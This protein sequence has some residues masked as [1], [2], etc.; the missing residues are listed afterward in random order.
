LK[1]ALEIDEWQA[2]GGVGG[3][4]RDTR[5]GWSESEQHYPMPQCT[6][7]CSD[8]SLGCLVERLSYRGD[9]DFGTSGMPQ[10]PWSCCYLIYRVMLCDEVLLS[11]HLV[12]CQLAE[13]ND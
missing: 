10:K 13:V 7:K 1:A 11:R 2:M 5:Y 9:D 4:E 3:I 8:A 12:H 6:E